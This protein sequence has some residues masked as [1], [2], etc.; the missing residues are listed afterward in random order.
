MGKG[1]R[2]FDWESQIIS[3]N[4]SSNTAN[5]PRGA[6]AKLKTCYETCGA[7]A[8]GLMTPLT[9]T[10]VVA[11]NFCTSLSACS[12]VCVR[13]CVVIKQIIKERQS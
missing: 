8:K 6:G 13:M 9:V 12:S 11:Q 5:I 10:F 2:V 3:G 7:F 1:S 4:H